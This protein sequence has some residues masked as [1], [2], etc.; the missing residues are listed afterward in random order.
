M[1]SNNNEDQAQLTNHSYDGIQEY[2][3]PLPNWWLVTFFGAIIFAF[4]YWVHFNIGGGD[5]QIN[6]LT[7]EMNQLPK[8]KE[9]L[10]AEADFANHL[11]DEQFKLNGAMVYSGKCASCHAPDGGGLIGPNLTDRAWKSGQGKTSDIANIV[12]KGV[13]EK[14]MPAWGTILSEDE[15]KQVSVFVHTLQGK[16]PKN[17]KAAEGVEVSLQ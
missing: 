15:L 14:G 2:D 9:K 6:E 10:W 7:F 11:N 3:N 8:Q 1:N 12:S 5:T 4:I 17:P 16:S 13:V